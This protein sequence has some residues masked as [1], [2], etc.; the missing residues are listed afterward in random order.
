MITTLKQN[1]HQIFRGQFT[2]R[3]LFEF[4]GPGRNQPGLRMPDPTPRLLPAKVQF[5]MRSDAI[6]QIEINEALIR[7]AHLF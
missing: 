7:N 6:S 1:A 3:A 2:S 4:G 5:L